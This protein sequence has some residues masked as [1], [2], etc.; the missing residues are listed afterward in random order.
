MQNLFNPGKIGSIE[1]KNRI[2]MAPMGTTGLVEL[3]GRYSQR[4]IDHFVAR[5]KG[6]VGLIET[7]LMAVDVEVEKRWGVWSHIPRADSGIYIARLNEL[8]DGVHEYGS[9]IFAQLTAGFGRVARP[10]I[11]NTSGAIAP[12]TQPCYWD[13]KILARGLQ[14]EEIKKLI[15][16]FGSAAVILKMAG[17]DGIEIHAHEGYLVD[18]FMTSKWNKRTDEYG[19][20]LEGRLK[21]P[22]DIV[23]EIRR[24][25]GTELPIVFRMAG[26][27]FTEGGRELKE[28]IEIAKKLQKVGIDAFHVDAGCYDAW[29][30]A[31]PPCYMEPGPSI[32]FAEAIKKNVSIPVIAVGRL[33]YPDLAEKVIS[34]G[35]ADFVALGRALLADPEWPIKV[36]QGHIE[37]IRPCIGCH[38]GCLGRI[39]IEGKYL[40]CAVNP[41]TGMEKELAITPAKRAK[42]ILVIGG[43]P[44]GLEAARVLALRGNKVTLWDN[45]NELGGKLIAAG[46]PKFKS[47]LLKLVKYLSIQVEK[48]GVKVKLN[49]KATPEDIIKENPEILILATGTTTKIPEIPGVDKKELKKATDV[50]LEKEEVG[51][52][53]IIIGGSCAGCEVALWLAQQ[54]KNVTIIEILNEAMSDLFVANKIQLTEML[55]NENVKILTG[56]KKIKVNV[57]EVTI[58]IDK[59]NEKIVADT[60]VLAAGYESERKL[61]EQLHEQKFPIHLI[62]DC[63]SPGKIQSAIWQAY[64]LARKI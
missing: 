25:I 19:G 20:N 40:S 24:E 47:D 11:L 31:H 52:K 8:T 59:K 54:G 64:R 48:L 44:A 15:K 39:M 27:H 35:K 43:G 50:L 13:N 34:T 7:G 10:A 38:D 23:K 30:W 63:D 58:K 3:D 14:I 22:I 33:N 46:R 26:K 5:A 17:F 16:A 4:G 45:N 42:S 2:V 61:E 1:I 53:V 60:L 29:N 18:Q 37:D 9:K 32:G 6:G 57:N 36:K 12:S 28:S 21:F 51:Q 55:K 49:K 41:Q 56:V 62:G